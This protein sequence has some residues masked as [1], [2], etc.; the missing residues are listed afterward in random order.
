MGNTKGGKGGEGGGGGAHRVSWEE[1][2]PVDHLC[3]DAANGPD[4]HRRGVVLGAQQN[5]RCPVPQRD[6]LRTTRSQSTLQE[7]QDKLD[8][9]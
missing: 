4:I 3:K 2:S 1:G 7:L 6:H 9:P 5:L 8:M